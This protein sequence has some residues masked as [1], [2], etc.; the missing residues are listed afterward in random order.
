VVR[1]V[2]VLAGQVVQV[3]VAH[4]L[5]QLL[6]RKVQVVVLAQTQVSALAV[7]AVAHRLLVAMLV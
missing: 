4:H 5:L 1:V 2:V 3:R 7:V 6:Q